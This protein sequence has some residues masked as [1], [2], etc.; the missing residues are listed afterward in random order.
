MTEQEKLNLGLSTVMLLNSSYTCSVQGCT[1]ISHIV[2]KGCPNETA[3]II[4]ARK[5]GTV[6]AATIDF[7]KANQSAIA[8]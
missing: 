4:E 5:I 8:T 7:I 6:Q 3:S 2:S 1:E